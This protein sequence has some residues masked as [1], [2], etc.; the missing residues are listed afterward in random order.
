MK[1]RKKSGQITIFIIVAILIVFGIVIFLILKSGSLN[2]MNN[3]INRDNS[4]VTKSRMINDMTEDCIDKRTIDAL[5]LVSLHGGYVEVPAN[6]LNLGF[7][8]I[9]LGF[10]KSR[11]L[12]RNREIIEKEIS[13]YLDKSVSYCLNLEDFSQNITLEKFQSETKIKDNKV[14]INANFE[15]SIK[16]EK[17]SSSFNQKFSNDYMIPLGNMLNDADKIIQEQIKSGK[18]IPISYLTNNRF[19]VY[20]DFVSDA[21]VYYILYDKNSNLDGINYFFITGGNF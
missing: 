12:L 20:Y 8:E 7:T 13:N 11:K 2:N 16:N 3:L 10:D 1:K 19:D 14:I 4:I 21:G 17:S 6:F 18:S 5:R 15:Y 9:G